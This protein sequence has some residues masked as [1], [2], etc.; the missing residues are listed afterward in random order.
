MDVLDYFIVPTK[1]ERTKA[2]GLENIKK[3]KKAFIPHDQFFEPIHEPGP[4]DW[5]SQHSKKE[6]KQTFKEFQANWKPITLTQVYLLPLGEF[7]QVDYDPTSQSYSSAPS[8]TQLQEYAKAFFTLPVTLLPPLVLKEENKDHYLFTWRDQNYTITKRINGSWIQLYTK[9]INDVLFSIKKKYF[10]SEAFCVTGI[11]MYDLYPD[12]AWNF[13]FGQARLKQSVGIFSFIRYGDYFYRYHGKPLKV[14]PESVTLSQ[15]EYAVLLKR[16]IK[17][18]FHE[19][20]HMFG[21]EHCCY[22]RCPMTGSNNLVESDSRPMFLC[23]MDL[24]KLQYR[25]GFDVIERYKAL[26]AFFLKYES[27]F[28][29]ELLWIQRRLEFITDNK[30]ENS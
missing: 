2:I 22:F 12:P 26:E 27:L 25:I 29:E 6:N 14:V 3:H 10:P 13:V 23:P 24:H 15:D 17:V 28:S 18:M 11:T 7:P 20:C 8:I 9:D 4:Y 5:L 30:E 16:S 1:A 19:T 21:I